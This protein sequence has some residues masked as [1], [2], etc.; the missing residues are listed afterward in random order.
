MAAPSNTSWSGDF[1]SSGKGRIGIAMSKTESTDTTYTVTATVWFWTQYSCS[2]PSNTFYAGWGSDVNAIGSIGTKTINTKNNSGSGW[3]TDNQVKIYETSNTFTR[4]S[5]DTTIAFSAKFTGVQYGGGS[6]SHVA[7]GT[8]P[9]KPAPSSFILTFDPNGGD[10]L[11]PGGN[12]NN[13]VN[14]SSVPVTINTSA[15]WAMSGDI[16][17]R[18]GYTF[19][20]WFDSTIGG[21]QVYSHTGHCLDGD[22]WSNNNWIYNGDA[23]VYAHWLPNGTTF[24][25]TYDANGGSGSMEDSEVIWGSDFTTRENEFTR[26]GYRFNGWKHTAPDGRE[27]TWNLNGEG[28]GESGIPWTWVYEYNVTLYAQWTKVGN[29]ITFDGNG[30]I[31]HGDLTVS[32][33]KATNVD[34]LLNK[35]IPSKYGSTFK[36]WTTTPEDTT[37]GVLI[38]TGN[39]KIPRVWIQRIYGDNPGWEILVYSPS[40][41]SFCVPTWTDYWGQNENMIDWD[42]SET[43]NWVKSYKG[44]TYTFNFRKLI[45]ISRY[46]GEQVNYNSHF[47]GYNSDGSLLVSDGSILPKYSVEFYWGDSFSY[48]QDVTFYAQWQ[49][50]VCDLI[51]DWNGG[52]YLGDTRTTIDRYFTFGEDFS[53]FHDTLNG[54]PTRDY[55]EYDGLYDAKGSKVIDKNMN[56]VYSNGDYFQEN[57]N[58]DYIYVFDDHL[59]LYAHWKPLN[60]AHYKLNGEW[61][62][63]NSYIK[64]DGLWKPAIFYKN[65]GGDYIFET[66][67]LTDEDATALTDESGNTLIA[68]D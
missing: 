17:T 20:G 21:K 29:I 27:V 16:P 51:I 1:S 50:K 22:Y 33:E 6:G 23:T 47:Y 58:G 14:T 18:T 64:V 2:D 8:I 49:P 31:V 41:A 25:V 57:E 35:V 53:S 32:Y 60:L 19:T 43:G 61:V 52:N 66:S 12:L 56:A 34:F 65:T 36:Y 3:S 15:Y 10:L 11:D 62:L 13:G 24:T 54:L 5:S 40:S 37:G 48:N 63:C 4:G 46:K 68:I 9:A 38:S 30:G 44:K 59:V 26:L 28:M 39:S 42:S 45:Y 67:V 55:Y 7:Y